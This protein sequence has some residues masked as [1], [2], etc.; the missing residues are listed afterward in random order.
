M[1]EIYILLKSYLNNGD[2]IQLVSSSCR[3]F[4]EIRREN[5]Y[6]N[7]LKS[8]RF[9]VDKSYRDSILSLVSRSDHQISMS[10]PIDMVQKYKDL[11]TV[12]GLSITEKEG[13]TDHSLPLLP[14]KGIS[15]SYH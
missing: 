14:A 10:L 7:G 8:E 2:L 11:L 4:K 12:D 15:L 3:Y 9:C 6:L 5:I 13:H 1:N